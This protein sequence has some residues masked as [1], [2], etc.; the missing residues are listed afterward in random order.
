MILHKALRDFFWIFLIPCSF[1]WAFFMWL[2]RKFHKK[3]FQFQSFI[4]CVGN[5]HSGG[6]G[7]TPIT[8]ELGE[9]LFLYKPVIISRGYGKKSS[10]DGEANPDSPDGAFIYGEEPWLILKRL[11]LPVFIGKKREKIISMIEKKYGKSLIIMDDGFQY[12]NLKKDFS[13]V[14][15][16]VEKNPEESFCIPYGELREPFSSLKYASAVLLICS[17][18]S[19]KIYIWKRLLSNFIDQ[20]KIYKAYKK[21]LG[22]NTNI[23]QTLSGKVGC[24]CGI[25]E[26]ETFFKDVENIHSVIFKK[27][28]KDHHQYTKKDVAK[29]IE[30][31]E[32]TG[33]QF[34][35]TTEKDWYKISKFDVLSSMTVYLR[36]GYSIEEA[37]WELL[38]SKCS[39]L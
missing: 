17:N 29:L 34:L 2:R 39:R 16:N 35:V 7:K 23:V 3:S 22:F 32:R 21:V 10:F 33:V 13:I 38:L 37:F 20:S 14:C 18:E 31:K 5:I 6:S 27:T 11:N 15:I 1:L 9:K 26:P 36:I 12:L 24:F 19:E 25:A 28:F 30:L 4:I 8:L